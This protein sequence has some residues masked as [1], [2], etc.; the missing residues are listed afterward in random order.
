MEKLF[1]L[2]VAFN[3]FITLLTVVI[4]VYSEWKPCNPTRSKSCSLVHRLLAC[5][6]GDEAKMWILPRSTNRTFGWSYQKCHLERKQTVTFHCI[7]WL[8]LV[9]FED[10]VNWRWRPFKDGIY[11]FC[12][13]KTSSRG[14]C[15]L[16]FSYLFIGPAKLLD[17]MSP[18][19][20]LMQ[21]GDHHISV[22]VVICWVEAA[23]GW[24]IA[25]CF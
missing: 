25:S 17:H 5:N 14:C 15:L 22:T 24:S 8:G 4:P 12:L 11:L 18:P 2:R 1:Y 20:D 19:L 21:V 16:N 7:Y 10:G 6:L 23:W 9:L 3:I 13:K